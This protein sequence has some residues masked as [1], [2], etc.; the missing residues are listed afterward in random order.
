MHVDFLLKS[1]SKNSEKQAIIW[2]NK[3]FT[4]KWLCLGILMATALSSAPDFQSNKGKF[5]VVL[6]AGHG[7][8]DSGNVGN[9][10]K[11]SDIE[12]RIVKQVGASLEK[13]KDI[14]VKL[15]TQ[16]YN[17][18]ILQIILDSLMI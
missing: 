18:K 6:D 12:L 11:E 5:V 3:I 7:G 1:F 2:K 15:P 14:K 4:Y 9:G 8:T 13:N 17:F 16:N 10:Y